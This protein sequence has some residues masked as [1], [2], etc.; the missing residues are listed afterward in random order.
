M[1]AKH[2]HSQMLAVPQSV[3][4]FILSGVIDEND[5]QKNEMWNSKK[6]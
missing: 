1:E 5:E 3:S 6:K 2:S 4:E